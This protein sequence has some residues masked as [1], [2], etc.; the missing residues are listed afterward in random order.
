MLN[1]R[2]IVAAVGLSAAITLGWYQ[3][4]WGAQSRSIEKASAQQA[5]AVATADQLTV[6]IDQLTKQK[7]ELDAH[8][9]REQQAIAAIPGTADL[10]NLLRALRAKADELGV[11]IPTLTPARPAEPQVAP[12]APGQDAAG[13]A[14]AGT[15]GSSGVQP[16]A[17]V[18]VT[19]TVT[20][21]YNAVLN[22]L[23]ALDTMP[24][25]LVTNS[26][27]MSPSNLGQSAGG[28]G[29]TDADPTGVTASITINAYTSP[30]PEVEPVASAETTTTIGGQG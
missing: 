5:A 4:V 3:F 15:P 18:A 25:L 20:G 7:A 16:A 26:V 17:T 27:T 9:E 24:R 6:D 1:R 21:P 22:Y 2:V 13:T 23:H 8:P 30:A 12:V 14:D 11:Q 10:A 19:M 28:S 29:R